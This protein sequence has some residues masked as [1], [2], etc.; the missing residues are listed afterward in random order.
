VQYERKQR[1]TENDVACGQ[2]CKVGTNGKIGG[3]HGVTQSRPPADHATKLIKTFRITP[4]APPEQNAG[5]SVPR[6][7]D[8]TS[9]WAMGSGA[10]V[11]PMCDY[12]LHAVASRP[13]VAGER[14]VSTTFPRT[15]TRGF[16]AERDREVAVCLLPGT[17]LGFDQDVKYSRRWIWPRTAGFSVAR[18]S[19][20]VADSHEHCDA[21]EF[22]DGKIVLL[23]LLVPGQRARVIQLPVTAKMPIV[24]VTSQLELRNHVPDRNA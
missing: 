1:R 20:I 19:K 24:Q 18:F 22:P 8:R 14:L 11:L 12:S 15:T 21:L 3:T 9:T 16:A 13:A 2:H 10:G 7:P 23:T 6:K 5:N 4:T 17:E